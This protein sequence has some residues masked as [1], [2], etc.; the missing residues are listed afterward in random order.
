MN[1]AIVCVV[2][3]ILSLAVLIL[4]IY[5]KKDYFMSSRDQYHI[6]LLPDYTSKNV[7]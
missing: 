1:E 2:C 7:M 6:P 4:L 3:I 5:E